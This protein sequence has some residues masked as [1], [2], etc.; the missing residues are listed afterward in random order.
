MQLTFKFV[1][2][3]VA[4]AY[5]GTTVSALPVGESSLAAR[6][7]EYEDFEAREVDD[8]EFF[9][10]EPVNSYGNTDQASGNFL[11]S[12]GTPGISVSPF[13]AI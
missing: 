4:L 12:Y 3:A 2:I 9:A 1:L 7:A 11:S 8:I 13:A 6:S 5:G 10:R